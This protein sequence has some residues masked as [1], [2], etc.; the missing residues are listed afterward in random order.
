[1]QDTHPE[2][3]LASVN[4][5][6]INASGADSI[7]GFNGGLTG[8]I[9]VT[10]GGTLSATDVN[11]G[12]LN[13]VTLQMIGPYTTVSGDS[14]SIQNISVQQGSIDGVINISN[15]RPVPPVP[16]VPPAPPVPPHPVGPVQPLSLAQ[17]F[18]FRNQLSAYMT[19]LELAAFEKQLQTD[20]QNLVNEQIGT[21]IATD[22]TPVRWQPPTQFPLQGNIS[23]EQLAASPEALF[24]STEFNAEQ[25]SLLPVGSRLWSGD[26]GEF[27]RFDQGICA[28]YASE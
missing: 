6:I 28:A 3:R 21:R 19:L 12:N 18:A 17:I 25:L 26:Q 24:S 1:M 4:N 8:A 13:P 10:G 22:Y 14:F 23:V 15:S 5:G 11:F 9:T 20:N 16:P 27:P 7:I 2:A